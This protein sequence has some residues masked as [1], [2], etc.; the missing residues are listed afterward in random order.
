M[1]DTRSTYRPAT[2]C[3]A[4][5]SRAAARCGETGAGLLNLL[6]AFPRFIWNEILRPAWR[7]RRLHGVLAD[8]T[9]RLFSQQCVTPLLSRRSVVLVLVAWLSLILASQ[10][11]EYGLHASV[12]GVAARLVAFTLVP[13]ITAFYVVLGSGARWYVDMNRATARG[14]HA[15]WRQWGTTPWLIQGASQIAAT[16]L[17]AFSLTL[18]NLIVLLFAEPVLGGIQQS[19]LPHL[20]PLDLAHHLT[21]GLF[22]LAIAKAVL[23]AGGLVAWF[24][25]RVAAAPEPERDITLVVTRTTLP[26]AWAWLLAEAASWWLAAW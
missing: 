19:L 16:A 5:T 2:W 14:E 21:P 18:L 23:V 3:A 9:R 11:A 15:L 7:E 26:F 1:A 20:P 6:I 22:L 4:A 17:T 8:E 12:E 25:F 24:A 13:G 10:A